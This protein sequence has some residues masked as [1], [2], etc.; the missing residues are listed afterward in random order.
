MLKGFLNWYVNSGAIRQ[1]TTGASALSHTTYPF[2]RKKAL[3]V[4]VS[5]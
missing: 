3:A 4:L 5:K 2:C 1:M